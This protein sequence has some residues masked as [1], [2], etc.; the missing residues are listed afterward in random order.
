MPHIFFPVSTFHDE[1]SFSLISSM[2]QV[3]FPMHTSEL[4]A[5]LG[6]HL[7]KKPLETSFS[8]MIWPMPIFRGLSLLE[9]LK[10]SRKRIM[11]H[12]I[13]CLCWVK[14]FQVREIAHFCR[15]M[16]LSPPLKQRFKASF[17]YHFRTLLKFLEGLFKYSNALQPFTIIL[18]VVKHVFVPWHVNCHQ[19][20]NCL[21][22]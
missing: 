8:P 20:K 16:A 14:L 2:S 13:F 21:R 7:D 12:S 19:F 4:I 6:T 9:S 11:S 18:F 5:Q 3:S 15:Q 1:V 17:F 22:S 10:D